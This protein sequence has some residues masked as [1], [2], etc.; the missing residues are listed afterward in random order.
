MNENK[1]DREIRKSSFSGEIDL[2]GFKISC[3]VLEDG[4]RVLV[5]RSLANAI[6]IKGGG[7]YWQKKK[8]GGAALPEY[9]SAKYLAPF[10]PEDVKIKL[11]NP[12]S[13]ENKQGVLTEGVSAELL[14]DICDIYVKAGESGAFSDNQ[15]VAENAYK[16]LFAFSKVGIIALVD[17]ATGYQYD[18]EKDELQKI[19]KAY[20]AEELLPWEKRFPDEFY[21]EIFRLNK[22]DFTVGGIKERPGVI[23]T[24]TK[25]FIY[26]VL[27]PGV[28]QA[29]LHATERNEKGKLKN[30]LHQHLTKEQGVEHLNKQIVS[31]VTL[32]NVS[33]TWKGFEKLWNKKFGQQ[34]LPFEDQEMIEAK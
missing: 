12:I 1:I 16:I 17:E 26:S 2:N 33:D 11:T 22:W 24:W 18:R 19:L 27:P 8:T 28:L 10:I 34:E 6:G 9:L 14:A 23:G 31:T 13:Y 32:M 4:T 21:K 5:N 29:L 7:T 3:A 30:R 20:I 25:K 15:N